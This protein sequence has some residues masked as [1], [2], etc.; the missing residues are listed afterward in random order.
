MKSSF[1]FRVSRLGLSIVESLVIVAVVLNVG[2]LSAQDLKAKA[3][4]EGKLMMYATFTAA[5][6]KTLL[7]GFKQVYPK[8]D[9]GILSQQ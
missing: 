2:T 8:I 3:E 5:D 6:S 9:G 1:G 4:A 7:D